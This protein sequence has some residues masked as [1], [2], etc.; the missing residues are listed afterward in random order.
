MAK[1]PDRT[2]LAVPA[3][4][5][6]VAEVDY[7]G[8]SALVRLPSEHEDKALLEFATLQRLRDRYVTA[9][10][11]RDGRIRMP[12]D[13]VRD[14][15]L[16]L[17]RAKPERLDEDGVPLPWVP[18]CPPTEGLGGPSSG[19]HDD[20]VIVAEPPPIDP[21]RRVLDRDKWIIEAFDSLRMRLG[22]PDFPL[23]LRG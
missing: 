1:L 23:L 12:R 9:T 14:L 13:D 17:E 20:D 3:T 4:A 21:E 7:E 10:K 2:S 11:E 6:P 15:L 8:R 19:E 22:L 5:D 18:A 16:A